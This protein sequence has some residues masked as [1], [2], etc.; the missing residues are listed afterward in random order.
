M[1]VNIFYTDGV[2]IGLFILWLLLMASEIRW[3]R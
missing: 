1:G 2:A 3:K